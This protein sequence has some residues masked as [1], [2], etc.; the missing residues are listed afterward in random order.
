MIGLWLYHKV[1]F[2]Y[3]KRLLLDEYLVLHNP[4]ELS[5]TFLEHSEELLR[6]I[7]QI[8]ST[9]TM[10]DLPVGPSLNH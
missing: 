4:Y 5:D 6:Q 7:I 2:Q 3:L 8:P 9:D 1:M 10:D